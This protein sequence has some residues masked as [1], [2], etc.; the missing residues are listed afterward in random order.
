MASFGTLALLLA[1]GLLAGTDGGY[2]FAAIRAQPPTAGGRD[3][4]AAARAGRRRIEGRA[5][6]AACLAAARAS[7]GADPCL[8]ADERRDDQ[9]RGLRLHPHRL[10][11]DRPG[12]M[13]VERDRAGAGRAHRGDRP[14]LR[15]DAKRSQAAAGLQHDR[16][17]RR[18]LHR[19]RPR[20][21]VQGERHAGGG[22]ARADRGAVPCAQPFDVQEPVVLRR[23]R[24]ARPRPASATWS[25]S[26][27]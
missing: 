11:S 24:R 10:R 13:V 5:R 8:G 9:G 2:A 6:P 15:A 25:A 18:H 20:A 1:F 16:E 7:G 22:G 17:H 19:A 4:G 14:A 12:A 23:R 26:A 27:G 3:P 21:G